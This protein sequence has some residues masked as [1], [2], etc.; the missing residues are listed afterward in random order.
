MPKTVPKVVVDPAKR[1]GVKASKPAIIIL[2]AFVVL[3]VLSLLYYFF[4]NSKK[5]SVNLSQGSPTPTPEPEPIR[6]L[7]S[8]KQTYTYSSTNV[9]GPVPSEVTIDPLTPDIGSPQTILVKIKHPSPITTAEV[10]LHT[11]SK[12]SRFPL[13]LE[14]GTSTDGTWKGSW[15]MPDSYNYNYYVQFNLVSEL[16]GY[17]HGLKFR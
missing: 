8:G 5:E 16:G 11:D 17:D 3:A 9:A 14:S 10:V 13:T 1:S 4:S 12:V 7:P 2:A 15:E 6:P